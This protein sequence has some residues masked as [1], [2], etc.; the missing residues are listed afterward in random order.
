MYLVCVCVCLCVCVYSPVPI[1]AAGL[2]ALVRQVF[3]HWRIMLGLC[4]ASIARYFH[5]YA[6]QDYLLC[7]IMRH[8]SMLIITTETELASRKHQVIMLNA[9]PWRKVLLLVEVDLRLF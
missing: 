8:L 3:R 9:H 2:Y 4:Y 6:G 7:S 1:G 5:S